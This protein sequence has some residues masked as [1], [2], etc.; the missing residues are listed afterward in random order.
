MLINM[1][2]ADV[3]HTTGNHNRLVI[4]P[5]LTVEL[6]FKGTKVSADIW[7]AKLI[8][9]R[10]AANRTLNHYVQRTGDSIRLT[11]I[12]FPSFDLIRNL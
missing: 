9:K 5:Y 2:G 8:V 1:I 11:L 7:P 3:T 10:G 4:A 6:R 12:G